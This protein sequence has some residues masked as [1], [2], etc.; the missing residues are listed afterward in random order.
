MGKV[1]AASLPCSSPPRLIRI[2]ER[3]CRGIKHADFNPDTPALIVAQ[4]IFQ[5]RKNGKQLDLVSEYFH[6]WKLGRWRW[7]RLIELELIKD[8]KCGKY[9]ICFNSKG[10]NLP[11][12]KVIFVTSSACVKIIS[13]LNKMSYCRTHR[14]PT[15]LSLLPSP[16]PSPVSSFFSFFSP[17]KSL[18]DNEDNEDN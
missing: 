16:P 17:L 4:S 1:T 11:H 13:T 9:R 2:L 10:S 15:L 14:V 18:E 7:G 12:P 3:G 5:T 6:L 8:A